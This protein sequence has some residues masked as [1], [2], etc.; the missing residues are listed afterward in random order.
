M[1]NSPTITNITDTFTT[2][3]SNTNAVSLDLGATGS[4]NTNQDSDLVGA[5]NEL[6]LGLRGTSNNLVATDLSMFAANNVVSALIELDVDIHGSG[7]GSASADL[8]TTANDLV[9]AINEVD[10]LQGNVTM[11]TTATTTTGA[12]K[13]HDLELGTITAGAMGTTASTVSGAI[14]EL[15]AEIDVLNT[16]V[17]PT[18]S[19][20]T[21]SATLSDA[22]NELS[23]SIGSGGLTTTAQTLI[24]GINEHD[25]EIGSASLNTAAT[26]LRG[27]I[28]ELHTEVGDAISGDNVTA[29]N[30]G[31]SLN[32]L[33]SA[34]GD[35]TGLTVTAT[36]RETLVKAINA[37][38]AQIDLLDSDGT[39]VNQTL[40]QLYNLD[41]AGFVGAERNNF[42][43]AL[44][45][46]RAD[47]PLIYDESGTQL[48]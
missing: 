8:T 12:I 16:R 42:V 24:G 38:K 7:G 13:E 5:V 11:G 19:L 29:G 40:G 22:V 21:A 26:T 3:V 32:L 15:E 23:D 41:S 1:A 43:A 34:V 9:S 18:Q 46:L 31:S 27:A 44:N 39:V 48:N 33:D 47:I 6:E 10:A 17:E 20:T 4:L 14:A 30:I 45:A 37:N 35:L 36:E 2:L 28:N 25:T